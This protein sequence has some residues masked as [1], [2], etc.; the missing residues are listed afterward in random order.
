MTLLDRRQ[1]LT[2]AAAA[3]ALG[4]TRAQGATG[5]TVETASGKIRG[6][7]VE[8]VNAFK[9]IPYGAST[10][11]KNRYMPPQKVQP[12][13]GVRD[14]LTWGPESPQGK[15]TEIP[16]VLATIPDTG[17]SED[18]LHLNVWTGSLSRNAKRPVLVWLHGG[19]FTSGSGS[20][21]IYDGT[22]MARDHGVVM[23]SVNHRLNTFGFLY[24][25]EA[26]GDRFAESGN[27]GMLDVVAALRWVH[28]N[29][30]AF[31]GDPNN[32]T[33]VGQS[34]GGGKVSTLLAMPSAKGL[35]HRAIAQSGAALTGVSK[36]AAAR[37]AQNF[38]S[39][40]GVKSADELQQV[41]MDKLVALTLST[42]GV[43]GG[44]VVDGIALPADPFTPSAPAMS[45]EIPLLIGTTE[46]E[47]NFFPFTKLDP[48]D[49]AALHAAV[50][51]ATR[52]S[53]EATDKL[54]GVYRQG[55]PW[56]K[57]VDISQIVASDNFRASV[58]TEAERKA[59]Q[60]APVYMYYFTWKTPVHDG[61]LKS[62]HT[63][64]IP[65]ALD[66]VDRGQSM[67][68]MGKDRYPLQDKMSSAWAAFA[69][70]GNPNHKGLPNWPAFNTATRDTMV[71]DNDCRV[72]RDPHKEERLALAALRPGR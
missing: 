65:F 48:I 26:G 17:I 45:A 22:N 27:V 7:H 4:A 21:S 72:V 18:C 50:K 14:A 33:I 34:G 57:D 69:K 38:L 62:F 60:K 47:V 29:I 11:G 35:F 70:S 13:T 53:D 64:D 68:G 46:F 67:T 66:N 24:L 36:T 37:A 39:K 59:E 20:Y 43:A 61:K 12:W 71:F 55:R 63:L 40:A 5:P 16:E 9:G 3:A 58:L 2:T 15:H 23:L 51:Q 32:V 28:D 30:E 25:G 52:S 41:S 8:G 6:A 49:D 19:G 10:A 44:P 42:Q 56:A 1:F 54:I 31:G